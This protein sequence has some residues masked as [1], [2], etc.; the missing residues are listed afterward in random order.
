MTTINSL[1][2]FLRALDANP[3]WREAI[4]TRIL[5]EELL[6]LPVKF[7]A[8]AQEQGKRLENVENLNQSQGE[9]CRSVR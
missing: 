6:Q 1:D 9:T 7:D 2:D 4:R 5:G 3:S 8:F